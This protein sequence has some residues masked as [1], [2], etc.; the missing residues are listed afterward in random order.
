MLAGMS[1]TARAGA[2]ALAAALTGAAVLA[3]TTGTAPA[4]TA[5]ART[6]TVRPGGA[7]TAT[8]GTTTLADTPT[9]AMLH[10]ASSRM[11]GALKAGSGLPGVGVGSFATVVYSACA[12]AGFGVKVT[13]R[14][15]PW[16]LNLTSYDARTGV[17]RGTIGHLQIG[18]DGTGFGCTA[19][20]NGTSGATPDGVVAVSYANKTGTLKILQAGGDLHWRHVHGCAGVVR[21]GDAA[22]LSAGY[23]VSPGQAITSP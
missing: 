6:W 1:A 15:L 11:S 9:G 13:A 20:L 23:A 16:E 3:T 10:C 22:T 14:G 12:A 2:M 5:A 7:I 21:D 4:A 18:V 19:V 17:A 8:A